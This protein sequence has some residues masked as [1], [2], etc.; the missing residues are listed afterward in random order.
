MKKVLKVFLM[1]LLAPVVVYFCLGTWSYLEGQ[2]LRANQDRIETLYL[3]RFSG[4]REVVIR[5]KF[6]RIERSWGA[7]SE[8]IVIDDGTR[9]VI[10]TVPA[11]LKS[12]VDSIEPQRTHVRLKGYM[13]VT[14]DDLNF[15]VDKDGVISSDNW[16]GG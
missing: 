12:S 11:I 2:N 8:S 9:T 15:T 4:D 13:G 7:S 14:T 6:S 10:F 3:F 16:H 5:D 1:L